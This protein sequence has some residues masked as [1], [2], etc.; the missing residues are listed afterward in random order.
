[1]I[2][3]EKRLALIVNS[4]DN[5]ALLQKKDKC[6]K[7]DYIVGVA[8]G[9]VGGMIDILLVGTPGDSVLG[10]WTDKQVD[11]AVMG[12]ARKMGWNPKEKNINNV[13]SA[14]GFLEHGKNNGKSNEFQGFKVNYDQI[15]PRDVNNLF[16]IRPNT[17]HMMSLGHSP[18]IVGLFFSILN[19]FTFTSTF[20]A[21][22]E[23]ITISTDSFEL[24]G[25][26]FIMKIMCG[27]ANW[28]GHLMSDV[29]GSS[30]ANGRG[31]GIVMPLYEFFNFCKFGNFSTNNG[32][33]DLAEIAMQA[34]TQGY[35]LRFG[36]TQAIPLVIT[37][38]SIRLIWSLRQRF[39]Y[40]KPIKECIP[41]MKHEDLR[42]ML[43][44]GNGTLCIMDGIDAG[45]RSG[46]NFL[47]FFMR[48]NMV[49]WFR[50]AT[51]VLKEVFIRVG[52]A[53]ALQMNIEAFKLINEALLVYLHKLKQI[54]I[55]LFK[56]ETEEYNKII[57]IFSLARTDKDLNI[58]LINTYKDLGI[59]KPWRGDFDEHMSDK[60]GTLR[61]E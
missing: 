28:F 40:H 20:I 45:V 59:K 5:R 48:L 53:D 13:N 43:L 34:F 23:L 9:A 25:G 8:C 56:K 47:M 41:T 16:N 58:M 15:K 50:F 46:G 60:N 55:E 18:D 27:I 52:I 35:D 1:M 29:A 26:N 3:E 19:Q 49:A 38:L 51:L 21:N 24:R 33:K 61:F 10:N 12:F 4:E 57:G 42:V 2:P 14:I 11:N 17:H 37:E 7:Y 22:G 44:F 30:G 6:D 31:T 39:Q 32:T 36:L 54:D